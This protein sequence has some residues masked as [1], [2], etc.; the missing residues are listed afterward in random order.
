M[1]RVTQVPTVASKG[2]G[3]CIK[4]V[5]TPCIPITSA[6]DDLLYCSASVPDP[7]YIPLFL[8]P[9]VDG[10]PSPPPRG[11]ERTLSAVIQSNPCSAGVDR[12]CAQAA[13]RVCCAADA[14]Q[15][16]VP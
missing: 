3:R 14:F 7:T 10:G 5:A 2:S 4:V 16:S 15:A 8:L 13:G 11:L 6:T 9:R 12:R 1:S